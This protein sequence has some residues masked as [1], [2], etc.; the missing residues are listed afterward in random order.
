MIPTFFNPDFLGRRDL[1]LR[2]SWSRCPNWSR[3]TSANFSS[4][5]KFSSR[6]YDQSED[7][8]S[9]SYPLKV[10]G[11]VSPINI[12]QPNYHESWSRPRCLCPWGIGWNMP[13][14][15]QNGKWSWPMYPGKVFSKK[16]SLSTIHNPVRLMSAF[17]SM[18]QSMSDLQGWWS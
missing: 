18:L 7:L 13:T 9:K 11:N 15:S 4:R 8:P 2:F 6:E 12:T 3:G 14:I 10:W 17:T 16:V 5:W 1:M